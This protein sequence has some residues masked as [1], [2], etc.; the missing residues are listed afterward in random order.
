MADASGTVSQGSK[1]LREDAASLQMDSFH[2][3]QHIFA[4]EQKN[5]QRFCEDEKTSR[6]QNLTTALPRKTDRPEGMKGEGFVSKEVK[7]KNK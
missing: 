4:G 2:Q 1:C 5:L 7:K 6:M 3:P